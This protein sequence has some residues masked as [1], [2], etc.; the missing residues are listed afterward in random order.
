MI[1]RS[2]EVAAGFTVVVAV[3]ELF[4]E[5]G[6]EVVDDTV[7]VFES[8]PAAVGVTTIAI[9]A[10]APFARVP[11]MQVTIEVPEQEPTDGVADTNVTPAGS[12]SLTE[13]PAAESGPPFAT[14]SV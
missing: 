10:E 5:L 11:R 8:G 6:S 1:D 4:A 7:A 3:A 13:T 12:V 9:V 2:A 14:V